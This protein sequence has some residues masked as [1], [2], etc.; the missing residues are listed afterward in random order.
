MRYLRGKLTYA[1]VMATVAVFIALGGAAYAAGLPK[2]SVGTKQ[3]K[4]NAV[5]AAKIKNGTITGSK[6]NLTTLGTVPSADTATTATSADTATNANNAKT[7]ATAENSNT[8]GGTPASGYAKVQLEPLHV[9]GATG[10]PAFENGCEAFGIGFQP[11]AFYKDPFG[12]VHLLG[13]FHHCTMDDEMFKLPSGFRPKEAERF[14]IRMEDTTTGTIR[15]EPDGE[16]TVFSG[17][18]GSLTDIQ[19]RTN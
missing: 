14:V 3:L 8:L 16:V 7:A 18:E 10:Q 5:T 1:N 13:D 19:F 15:V 12:V 9:I 17:T 6:I 4:N 11:P 2:N